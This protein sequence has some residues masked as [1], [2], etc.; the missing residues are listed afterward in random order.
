M[1]TNCA[2]SPTADK[3]QFSMQTILFDLD[4]TL[5]DHFTTIHRSIA[6][7]QRQLGLPESDYATV[8]ATVGGSTPVTLERLLGQQHV[9]TALPLFRAHFEAIMFEDVLPLPGAAWILQALKHRGEQL[10][11]FTN[12]IGEHSRATLQHLEM[13]QWLDAIVGTGDTP[14]R[15]PEPQFTAH[16]LELMG[17]SAAETILIGDSPFDCAAAEAGGLQCYLVATGSHSV[18]ELQQS[19]TAA[20]VYN[21]LYELGRAVFQLHPAATP[22]T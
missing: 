19:T 5:I 11:V 20:G 15:K 14:Y 21:D 8:R 18:A 16:M 22:T 1:G 10:A 13:D 7:A 3:E 9:E 2:Q 17:A 12:K 6:H 4:G